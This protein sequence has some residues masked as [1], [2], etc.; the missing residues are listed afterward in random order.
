MICPDE[1]DPQVIIDHTG[2]IMW[3]VLI[4]GVML[5][6]A[7]ALLRGKQTMSQAVQRGPRW[8]KWFV[9]G[10]IVWLLWHLFW[11]R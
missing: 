5:Y 7:I 8:L 6:E 11:P 9:G 3:I 10:G 4:I 1:V 2:T